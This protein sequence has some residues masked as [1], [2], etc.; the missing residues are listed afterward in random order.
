MLTYT[1][2]VE[3]INSSCPYKKDR[4]KKDTDNQGVFFVYTQLALSYLCKLGLDLPLLLAD[5]SLSPTSGIPAACQ[6][7]IPPSKR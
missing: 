3:L 6:P 7:P 5:A 1:V 4:E 2:G